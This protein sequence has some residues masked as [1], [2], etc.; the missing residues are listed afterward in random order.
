M[1]RGGFVFFIL[2]WIAVSATSVCL[3]ADPGAGDRGQE[4]TEVQKKLSNPVTDLWFIQFQQNN[5]VINTVRG[6][7]DRWNSNLCFQPMLPL[8]L[9]KDWSLIVRPVITLFNSMPFPSA[10][11][12]PVTHQP[13][14][15]IDK[16]MTFGDSTFMAMVSPGP[17]LV[18]N[19]IMGLGPT[20]IFP[21]ASSNYTGMGTWQAGPAAVFGYFSDKFVVAAF[22]QNWTSYATEGNRRETNVMNLQPVLAFFLPNGWSIGYS[23]NVLSN[24]KAESN[25]RWT[26]PLGLGV[27]KVVFLGRLPIKIGLAGQYMPIHPDEFGEKWNLQL[28]FTVVIPKLVKGT[29]L[30]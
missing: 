3:A 19:W 6:M 25:D 5:F 26:V 2:F 10:R 14:L 17:S 12:D 16:T 27:S 20:F 21:T 18:G 8:A 7:G 11:I 1:K 13:S 23:G 30:E 22:V 28:N 4:A 24:W 29:L 9:T 15:D